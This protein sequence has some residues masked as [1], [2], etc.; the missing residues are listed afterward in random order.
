MS[1]ILDNIQGKIKGHLTLYNQETDEV[2]LDVD[3]MVVDNATLL[4]TLGLSQVLNKIGF[5]ALT[6]ATATA[7]QS[8]MDALQSSDTYY[9]TASVA[10]RSSNS[11]V[12]GF[13]LGKDEFNGKNIREYGLFYEDSSIAAGQPGHRTMFSRIART[14]ENEDFIKNSTISI[15]GEWTVTLNSVGAVPV[16]R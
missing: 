6:Y 14:G 16:Y 1:K 13:T 11:V 9:V 12:F 3:N 8:G 15:R 5:G 2:L 7:T 4:Y 10:S